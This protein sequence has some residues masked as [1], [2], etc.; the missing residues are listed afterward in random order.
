MNKPFRRTAVASAVSGI[1]LRALR[2]PGVRLRVRAGR[3]ERDGTRQRLCRRRR[4]R[5][6][7]E[8]RVVQPRGSRAAQ[9]PAGRGRGPCDHPVGQVPECELAGGGPATAGRHRRR[10][11]RRRVRAEPV[12]I[13][14]PQ[15]Q[16]PHR[17]RRQRAVR[18]QDGLRRRL[19]RP[20]PGAQVRSQDDQRQPG[21]SLQSDRPVLDRRR[22]ELPAFRGDAHQQRELLGGTG[23]GLRS[24]RRRRPDHS[25]ASGGVERGNGGSRHVRQGHRRR[26]R[27][28]MERRRDVQLQRRR[29]QRPRRG[30]NRARLSVEAQVQRRRQRQLHESDAADADRPAGAA[31]IPSWVS[32]ATR[33]TRRASSTAA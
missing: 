3:A 22:R 33:S 24:G 28:G 15:R 29:Q 14:G 6:G 31:S 13:D 5:R 7:R 16:G 32:S 1:A 17:H 8:H 18:P 12:R 27:V 21:V 4:H 26:R 23:A 25:G 11:R 19:A 2:R 9:F 10:C 30:K 20:L